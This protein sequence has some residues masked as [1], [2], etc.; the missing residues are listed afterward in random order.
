MNLFHRHSE[1]LRC[2]KFIIEYQHPIDNG[3]F[4]KCPY[5]GC[6]K[7]Y[8]IFYCKCGKELSR[9]EYQF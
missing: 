5:K 6:T 7:K 4:R 1:D 2:T 8:R 9:K 3:K